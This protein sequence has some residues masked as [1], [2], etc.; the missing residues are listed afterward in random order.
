[1]EQLLEQLSATVSR[2]LQDNIAIQSQIQLDP[3]FGC[4]TTTSSYR[5]SEG[6]DIFIAHRQSYAD[7]SRNTT[8]ALQ[9]F[10]NTYPSNSSYVITWPDGS[11]STFNIIKP[12]S[13]NSRLEREVSC[14][15]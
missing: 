7:F 5:L 4:N 1:M 13:Q 2:V 9:N 12:I 3:N 6:Q 10:S 11:R 8:L 15:Y 14:G